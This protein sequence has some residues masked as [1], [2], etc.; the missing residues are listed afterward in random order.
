MRGDIIK[1]EETED[2]LKR[3]KDRADWPFVAG[4]S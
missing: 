2:A 3:R 1:D 4:T